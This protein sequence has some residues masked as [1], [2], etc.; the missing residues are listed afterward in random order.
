MALHVA[1]QVTTLG[2]IVNIYTNGS[3]DLANDIAAGFGS[4]APMTVDT[5]KIQR[6][7]LEADGAGIQLQFEDGSSKTEGF[8]AHTPVTKPRGP[9]AAQL[10]LALRPSGDIEAAPPF[11]Q[12]S[13]KG[14]YAAGDSCGM[15]KN[16]PHAIFSGSLA[17]M[18][19]S[20]QI[21]AENLGQ[22]SLFG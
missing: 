14:V 19:A 1:R 18:G 8:L 20:Q 5:R 9:F 17:G 22:T 10:G 21:V 4:V 15:M 7:I 3:E 2:K 13:V 12:T 11:Y 16:V 6:M